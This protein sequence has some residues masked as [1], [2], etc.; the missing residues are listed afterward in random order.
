MNMGLEWASGSHSSVCYRRQG[1]HLIPFINSL[2]FPRGRDIQAS[3]AAINF[4]LEGQSLTEPP[5]IA[6][7]THPATQYLYLHPWLHT[8]LPRL[9]GIHLPAA[10]GQEIRI[11]RTSGLIYCIGCYFHNIRGKAAESWGGGDGGEGSSG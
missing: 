1:H 4:P 11:L 9:D 6:I 5:W 7:N 10:S 8:H 3:C 2:Y